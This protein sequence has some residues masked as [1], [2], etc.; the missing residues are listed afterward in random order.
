MSGQHKVSIQVWEVTHKTSLNPLEG[1]G[2]WHHQS[3]HLKGKDATV[4]DFMC[5]TIIDPATNWFEIVELLM[6]AL[7]HPDIPSIGKKGKKGKNSYE[8]I[9]K[10]KRPISISP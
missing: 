2:C 5:V 8:K 1:S 7:T 4:I 6:T 10:E 3:L 9:T